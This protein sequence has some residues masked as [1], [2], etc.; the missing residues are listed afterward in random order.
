MRAVDEG[1]ET[2]EEFEI[3]EEDMAAPERGA[4]SNS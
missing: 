3:D 1:T 2:P 4:S